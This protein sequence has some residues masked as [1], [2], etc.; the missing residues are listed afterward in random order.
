MKPKTHDCP[1]LQ[2]KCSCVNKHIPNQCIFSNPSSC[3]Q[4]VEW[5]E[6]HEHSKI[7]HQLTPELKEGMNTPNTPSNER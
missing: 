1:Y 2:G 7:K 3:L 5:L 4:Y 6:S